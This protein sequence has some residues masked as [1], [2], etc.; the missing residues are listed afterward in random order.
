MEDITKHLESLQ[1]NEEITTQ[2]KIG[3]NS[4]VVGRAVDVSHRIV[5]LWGEKD[6]GRKNAM[7]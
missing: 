1:E 4:Q 6:L 3:N 7:I 5:V 2:K